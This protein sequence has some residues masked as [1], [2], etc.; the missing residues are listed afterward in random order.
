MEDVT[1]AGHRLRVGE[2]V[3]PSTISANMDPAVFDEPDEPDVARD[4]NPHLA[5]G[6]GPHRRP[7]AFAAKDPP[8]SP[9]R[10]CSTACR[11]C[12][13]LRRVIRGRANSSCAP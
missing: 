12:G 4:R 6:H 11:T 5:F 3:L 13:W 1:I 2:I 8:R 7:G 9:R 10:S